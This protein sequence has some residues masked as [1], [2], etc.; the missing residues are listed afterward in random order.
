M[1]IA[2]LS[3]LAHLANPREGL[4]AGI[5]YVTPDDEHEGCGPAIRKAR[6]DGLEASRAKRIA[7]HRNRH[8]HK[9]PELPDAD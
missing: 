9:P 6:K 3:V 7:Y 2:A 5:G 4:H 8:Q 1:S